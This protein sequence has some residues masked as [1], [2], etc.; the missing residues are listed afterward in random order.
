MNDDEHITAF[1]TVEDRLQ[2]AISQIDIK[3]GSVD[4]L[5]V[6]QIDCLPN[7]TDR[8]H[9]GPVGILNRSGHIKGDED[10][11]FHNQ[12]PPMF[13]IIHYRSCCHPGRRFKDIRLSGIMQ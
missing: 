11:V 7:S 5:V 2:V 13:K 6:Y 3:N 10:F 8:T 12:Y 4:M 1:Q 9:N